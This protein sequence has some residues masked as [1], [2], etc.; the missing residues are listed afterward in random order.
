MYTNPEKVSIIK[1][2]TYSQSEINSA[3]NRHFELLGIDEL[4]KPDMHVVI[5]PNLVMKRSPEQATTTHP[6]IVRAVI[7]HLEALGVYD[8]TIAESPGGLYT[9]PLLKGIYDSCGM[10]DAV[11]GTCAK[12]NFDT[13]FE[14]VECPAENEVRSFPIIT[15]IKNADF[16]IS[17]PKLKTHCMTTLSGAVK[18]LFGTIP[19]LTKPEFHYRFPQKERFCKMLVDLSL[20]VKP[21]LTIVD[22]V[23][24]MEGDGPSA[25]IKKHTGLTFAS[26][27]PYVLDY[28][29]CKTISLDPQKVF[30]VSDSMERSLVGEYSLCG[31]FESE[32]VISDFLMPRSKTVDFKDNIPAFVRKPALFVMNRLFTPLPKV[33]TKNCIGCGKCAQ[34][35]PAK[36]ITIKNKKAHINYK[37]CIHCF[38]C[39]EMCPVSAIHVRRSPFSNHNSTGNNK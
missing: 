24:S 2:D 15:P 27:N 3:V 30:T 18:N 6:S 11:N 32:P 33:T 14:D 37:N 12:L 25:G 29:L 28:S 23:D 19:G 31:D 22:A 16:I 10:T 20:T 36:T 39:H 34:S 1:T 26:R 35:C 17:L 21:D 13:S 5:K 4:I 8:I 9:K 7:E 38:C